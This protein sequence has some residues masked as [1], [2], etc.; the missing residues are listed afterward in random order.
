MYAAWRIIFNRAPDAVQV[1]LARTNRDLYY[2]AMA[3]AK[4]YPS[5]KKAVGA[6]CSVAITRLLRMGIARGGDEDILRASERDFEYV[7][8]LIEEGQSISFARFFGKKRSICSRVFWFVHRHG[9]EYVRCLSREGYIVPCYGWPPHGEIISMAMGCK[10][11]IAYYRKKKP[12]NIFLQSVVWANGH[13]DQ[14]PLRTVDAEE[15][16]TTLGGIISQQHFNKLAGLTRSISTWRMN[17]KAAHRVFQYNGHIRATYHYKCS[18]TNDYASLTRC[19]I[20]AEIN[21]EWNGIL[22]TYENYCRMKPKWREI[23]AGHKDRPT[24]YLTVPVVVTILPAGITPL[25]A[26]RC[27]WDTA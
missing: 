17:S 8:R 4:Q 12:Y 16:I 18:R 13:G 27:R 14:W 25:Y 15:L 7:R 23:A 19:K 24:G 1:A 10:A 20:S 21:G 11:T 3:Y 22:R 2:C 5:L 9:P 26:D 6:N